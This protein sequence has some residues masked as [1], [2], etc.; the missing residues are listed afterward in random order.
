[1]S[2]F[3]T[4]C[5]IERQA[6]SCASLLLSERKHAGL[7]CRLWDSLWLLFFKVVPTGGSRKVL[8]T[9]ALGWAA[10]LHLFLSEAP[11]LLA[12]AASFWL[13][14]KRSSWDCLPLT[15][16]SKQMHFLLPQIYFINSVLQGALAP[17]SFSLL[18]QAGIR[19]VLEPDSLALLL[20][21]FLLWTFLFL[22]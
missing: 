10:L 18:S 3:Q 1:M 22:Q 15:V 12:W 17:F 8:Q 13:F 6:A 21:F 9:S 4:Q 5:I 2:A 14:N 11:S 7:H 19:H 20:L 16:W